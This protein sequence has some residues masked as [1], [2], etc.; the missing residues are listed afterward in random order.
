MNILTVLERAER[1]YRGL[2][3]MYSRFSESAHPNFDGVL[4][5]YSSTDPEKYETHF[6]N[7][8]AET[9]GPE[10]GPAMSFVFALFEHEYD[11]IWPDQFARLEGWLEENDATLEDQ[12]TSS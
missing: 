8:W 4:Y 12:R 2:T 10:Q 6:S 1:Q 3:D 5:P 11:K 9:F 7:R